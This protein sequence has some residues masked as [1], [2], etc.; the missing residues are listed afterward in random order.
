M[1]DFKKLLVWRKAH[2]LAVQIY[3]STTSFPRSEMFGLTAQLR[4][5]AV[6]VSANIAEGCGRKGDRDFGRYLQVSMSS[7]CELEYHF[8]LARD[9]GYVAEDAYQGLH[10]A[11]V[12]VKRML[13]GFLK[14]TR[15]S[16]PQSDP[17]AQL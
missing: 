9:L 17:D 1:Q 6:S 11:T 14:A 7:A 3:R 5:A 12:E 10:D 8:L 15:T 2:E 4:R 16:T 13:A